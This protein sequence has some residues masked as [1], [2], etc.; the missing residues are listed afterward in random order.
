ME[1]EVIKFSLNKRGRKLTGKARNYNAAAIANTIN[2]ARIQEQVKAGDMVGFYGHWPRVKFGLRPQTGGLVDGK[3]VAVEPALVTTFLRAAKDGTIEHRARF[4]DNEPGQM[5]RRLHQNKTGGFSAVI[6]SITH[7]IYGLDYVYDPNFIEN[8]GWSVAMDS[9][10]GVE[11][12]H[13]LM[14]DAAVHDY[15]HH[16]HGALVLLDSV[17]NAHAVLLEKYG[18]VLAEN[19]ELTLL[20]AS[21]RPVEPVAMDS[22]TGFR[23]RVPSRSDGTQQFAASLEEFRSAHLLPRVVDPD[24]ERMAEE[25][26]NDSFLSHLDHSLG[27]D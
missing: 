26:E 5:A 10:G 20:L 21:R 9:A 13:A 14:D 12:I 3:I 2:S 25:I 8:R 23:S 24:A 18:H 15:R 7:D 17:S 4:L 27:L 11:D 19:E 22:A 6:D 16:I 1:T